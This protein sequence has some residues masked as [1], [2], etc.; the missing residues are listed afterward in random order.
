MDFELTAEQKMI[1]DMAKGFA[2]THFAP[3]VRD[4]EE[5]G[6][7]PTHL[8]MEMAYAGLL[9]ANIPEDKGGMGL[10][11]VSQMLVAKEFS[12]VWAAGALA[13]FIVP[14]SLV[15]YPLAKYGTPEQI[16]KYLKPSIVGARFG[17]FGLTEPNYGSHASGVKTKAEFF[18]DKLWP[19]Y[20]LNGEKT[21]I[22]N[23][24]FAD[25]ILVLARTHLADKDRPEYDGLTAF[26]V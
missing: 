12:K 9:G 6:V 22:T 3:I 19:Y 21:F 18:D 8:F 20:L 16:E 11:A 5:R 17:C 25:F 26:I 23:V 14:N 1:Q 13:L 4:F 15:A 10:D 7:Y 2:A 24:T